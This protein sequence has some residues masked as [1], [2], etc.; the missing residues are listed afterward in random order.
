MGI[1]FKAKP[2]CLPLRYPLPCLCNAPM[3]ARRAVALACG[4]TLP[5]PGG[6]G[7]GLPRRPRG[8]Y[9]GLQVGFAPLCNG[10]WG[11]MGGVLPP[12]AKLKTV[13]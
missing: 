11:G 1:L 12:T 7:G 9:T 8:C 6:L 10:A 13:Q 2:F 5:Y 3:R 4:A